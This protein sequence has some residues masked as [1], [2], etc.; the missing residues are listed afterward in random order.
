MNSRFVSVIVMALMPWATLSITG[1]GG[2][3]QTYVPDLAATEDAVRRGLEAWKGGEP[4]G[5]LPGSPLV[6]V[7]DAGRKPGQTLE[8]FQILGETSGS[9]GRTIAVHLR[10]ANPAED[11]RTRYIVVGIDPLWVFRQ[12]DYDLLMHWDHHMPADDPR[13]EKIEDPVNTPSGTAH[14]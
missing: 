6:H 8:S 10:L 9:A 11:I 7:T 5:E 14:Q 12:E 1:C 2:K 3:P 4:P 13:E